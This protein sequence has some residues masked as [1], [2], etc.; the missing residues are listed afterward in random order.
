MFGGLPANV[1]LAD[2]VWLTSAYLGDDDRTSL[3]IKGMHMK[4]LVIGGCGFIGSHVVDRLLRQGHQVRIFDRHEE[5]FRLALAGVDYRVGDFT[6]KM[7]IADAVQGVD[8]VFHFVSTTFPGTASLNPQ[9]DVQENLIGTQQLVEVMLSANVR[10]LLFL[11]SGG[12]VYGIPEVTP[13]PETHPLRPINAYGITKTAIEHNLEMFR[14]VAGLSPIIVRASNPFGPRQ[15]HVGVQG[16]VST[17]LNR[18]ANG[19]PIEIWGDGSVI[20]DYIDVQDL[21]DFCVLAGTS[22]R[23]G[24]YNAGSGQGTSLV[25]LLVAMEEVTER[26]IVRIFRPARAIDVPVSI[27]DCFAAERDFGWKVQ[28]DLKTGLRTTWNWIL[29]LKPEAG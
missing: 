13:I 1:A 8:A 11:S 20:R 14:R 26:D 24:T 9:R 21:A 4:V 28:R 19:E 23:N 10:R 16:V 12:T 18:I 25:D 2:F 7:Q 27:L 29:S 22:D 5:N 3:A 6:N 17:F 15:S